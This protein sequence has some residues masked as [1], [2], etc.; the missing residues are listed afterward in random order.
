MF[1]CPMEGLVINPGKLYCT[2]LALGK[3]NMGQ[4]NRHNL[5]INMSIK[6]QEFYSYAF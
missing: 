2:S 3:H 6:V 1:H 4:T 5:N